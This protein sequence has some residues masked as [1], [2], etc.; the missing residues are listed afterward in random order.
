MKSRR[1][2]DLLHQ[3][4]GTHSTTLATIAY[5]APDMFA[6]RSGDVLLLSVY[7]WSDV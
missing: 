5:N 3:P 2:V 6:G 1:G 4:W 7:G